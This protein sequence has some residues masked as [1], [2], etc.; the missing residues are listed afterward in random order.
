[1]QVVVQAVHSVAVVVE[2]VDSV[3]LQELLVVVVQQKHL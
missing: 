1:L 2:Q 3:H